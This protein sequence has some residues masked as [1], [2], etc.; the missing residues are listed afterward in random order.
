[1]VNKI[2]TDTNLS[3][4]RIGSVISMILEAAAQS[5]FEMYA[6]LVQLLQLF[7]VDTTAGGDLEKRASE[8]GL[9]RIPAGRATGFV[10]I[11]DSSFE[12]RSSKIY[13]GLPPP[14]I[15][16]TQVF[17]EDASM[18]DSSGDLYIGRGTVNYEGP[19][20]YTGL[21]NNSSYWTIQLGA[22]LAKNHTSVERTIQARG[23]NRL[24]GLGTIVRS[25]PNNVS[26]AI[27][28]TVDRDVFLVDGENVLANVPVT[29][30]QPGRASN[31]AVGSISTFAALPFVGATVTNPSSFVNGRDIESDEDL[32]IRIKNALQV[33]ARGTKN[34]LVGSVKDASS[35][36]DNKRVTSAAL[37]EPVTPGLPAQLYIDDGTG[38]EPSFQGQGTERIVDSASGSEVFLQLANKPLTPPILVCSQNEP[39]NLNPGQEFTVRVD[40]DIETI[41]FTSE[42]FLV[43]G[44]VRLDEIVN[45]I[46]AKATLVTARSANQK[47]RVALVAKRTDPAVDP[48]EMQVLGGTANDVIGFPTNTT[49]TLSIYKNDSPLRKNPKAAAIFTRRRQDWD[50]GANTSVRLMIKVD[51]TPLQSAPNGIIIDDSNFA[52]Y[53]QTFA[54]ASLE[55]WA[56]VLNTVAAGIT[57]TVE[58]DRIKIQSNRRNSTTASIE[59]LAGGSPLISNLDSLIFDGAQTVAGVVSDYALNRFSGQLELVQR[60]SR[61]DNV[62]AGTQFTRGKLNSTEGQS[63]KYDFPINQDVVPTLYAVVDADTTLRS[64][65]HNVGTRYTMT[66]VN[67]EEISLTTDRTSGLANV[68]VGDFVFIATKSVSGAGVGYQWFPSA[69]TGIFQVTA[70]ISTTEVYFKNPDTITLPISSA[71]PSAPPPYCTINDVNDIQAFATD[72]FIQSIVLTGQ[73][74]LTTD[75]NK[76]INDG[77]VFL[78]ASTRTSN[79]IRVESARLEPSISAIDMAAVGGSAKQL[80]GAAVSDVA[81]EPHIGYL[82]SNNG[83]ATF[84]KMLPATAGLLSR[85]YASG[86]VY[87][88]ATSDSLSQPRILSDSTQ[89]FATT[90]D[91]SDT[92][93]MLT[94]TNQ[95]ALNSLF[96]IPS[97][98]TLRPQDYLPSLRPIYSGDKYVLCESQDFAVNDRL[99]VVLDGDEANKTF[100]IPVFRT[101]RVKGIATTNQF[102]AFDVDNVNT[103]DFNNTLWNTFTFKDFACS[104]RARNL[105]KSENKPNVGLVVRSTRYGRAGELVKFAINYPPAANSAAFAT[106]A[107]T[108]LGAKVDVFLPSGGPR[109]GVSSVGRGFNLS[110]SGTTITMTWANIGTTPN[111]SGNGVLVGDVVSLTDLGFQSKSTAF[112]DTGRVL[113]VSATQ[114]TFAVASAGTLSYVKTLTGAQDAS[115]PVLA[116]TDNRIRYFTSDTTDLAVGDNITIT[117]FAKSENNVNGTLTAVNPGVS[118]DLDASNRV[119]VSSVLGVQTASRTTN[120]LTLTF[121]ATPVGLVVPGDVLFLNGMSNSAFNGGPLTVTAVAGNQIQA[122]QTGVDV[123]SQIVSGVVTAGKNET[124][125]GTAIVNF[126]QQLASGIQ[127]YPVSSFTASA[128][129]TLL[130]DSETVSQVVYAVNAVGSTGS[131]TI[132]RATYDETVSVAYGHTP[133]QTEVGL[134][135]GENFIQNF[136]SAIGNANKN[137]VLKEALV[138]SHPDYNISSAPNKPGELQGEYFKLTPTTLRNSRDLLNLNAISPLNLFAEASAIADN[139]KL[140][141]ASKTLGTAGSVNVTGGYAN[142]VQS[143]IKS[144]SVVDGS[145]VRVEINQAESFNLN[146]GQVVEV[147]NS[148]GSIKPRNFDAG[149]VVDVFTLTSSVTRV[150]AL[151]RALSLAPGQNLAITDV[152]ASYGRPS[153]FVWRWT[154][155]SGVF[156]GCK[157]N[158]TL[159]A[160]NSAIA[161]VNRSANVY[162]DLTYAFHLVLG[163]DDVAGS[164][165]EVHNP[166]G[167]AESVTLASP[168]NISLAPSFITEYKTRLT[169]TARF[170]VENLR[171]KN[172]FKWTQTAGAPG[173]LVANGVAIDSYVRITGTSFNTL[174]RGTYRV[175]AVTDDYFVVENADGV[176]EENISFV[177]NDLRFFDSESAIPGDKLNIADTG[178]TS[179]NQ[180]TNDIQSVGSIDQIVWQLPGPT[181]ITYHATYVDVLTSTKINQQNIILT[182]LPGTF[183]VSDGIA[184]ASYRRVENVCLNPLTIDRAFVYLS[185][186]HNDHKLSDAVGTLVRPVTKYSFGEDVAGVGV[187]GYRYYTGLLATV[188]DIIDGVDEDPVNF[189]GYRAAGTQVEILPPLIKR[190][191]ISLLVKPNNGVALATIN[192]SILAVLLNYINTLGV[193]ESF[194]TS[195][196]IARVMGVQGVELVRFSIPSPETEEIT[197]EDREKAIA[198]I[199]DIT[200]LSL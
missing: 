127:V 111:F 54:N 23:G 189:P 198:T 46:N 65:F 4:L 180:G 188:Q 24:I 112:Q 87:G 176:E 158:D 103:I 199:N 59:L 97:S 138:F 135:D 170:K 13:I 105:Y 15:G 168:L 107:V 56:A 83:Q 172:L 1:M 173:R 41:A 134:Y 76:K 197:V 118:F 162:G 42:D 99:V 86:I 94:G 47:T 78:K 196:A 163:V 183:F 121:A 21:V 33:L 11:R 186:N 106:H 45:A 114:L 174:N 101:G 179:S 102:D 150:V 36:E 195:E 159:Y 157:V 12:T 14:I 160:N 39:Y 81:T 200:I 145:T 7:N 31:A 90:A 141:I 3:D 27:D 169:T 5:D 72:G 48:E 116:P 190:V 64:I 69:L 110:K 155:A 34:A 171:H 133:G 98:T 147:K 50:F 131:G 184:Y 143:A 2:I 148:L 132:S 28:F 128:L 193:G 167:L 85:R 51:G 108:P 84:P 151:P 129:V 182:G 66:R 25:Q 136:T 18:F 9:S 178:F 166:N 185:P 92:L 29:S 146:V 164:W 38:F 30:V 16:D 37:V 70:K 61:G 57:A 115:T 6:S 74:L 71:F 73:E 137:F 43:A 80:Y 32:R 165:I 181:P 49:R 22:P 175:V 140:Q 187:D 75:V 93:L 117:G 62:V 192:D 177:T 96:S 91:V 139:G 40:E 60:L 8:Y 156:S 17:V 142:G 53:G 10:T 100:N 109:L 122:T 67:A 44:S 124:G 119:A 68:Q 191:K 55:E 113:S 79:Q 58:I 95:R 88:A 194:I 35:S 125:A 153:G 52:V 144:P 130:Q 126:A 19:I 77:S 20:P 123:P 89:S 104:F 154:S 120:V 149:D 26:P 161:S 63:G 152:S 82:V